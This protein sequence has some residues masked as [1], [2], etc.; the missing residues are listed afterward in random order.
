[1]QVELLRD[2][3]NSAIKSS[4]AKNR[5]DTFC[6]FASDY[7]NYY[8]LFIEIFDNKEIREMGNSECTIKRLPD[9]FL[10]IDGNGNYDSFTYDEIAAFVDFWK[11]LDQRRSLAESNAHARSVLQGVTH[12]V[13]NDKKDL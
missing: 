1:M 6:V 2:I 8:P 13:K 7:E 4:D 12:L 9:G 3:I 10:V 5:F 11:K